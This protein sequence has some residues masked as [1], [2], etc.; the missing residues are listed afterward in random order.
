MCLDSCGVVRL[1]GDTATKQ[2]QRHPEIT[3]ATYALV[4][5]IIDEGEWLSDRS[6]HVVGFLGMDGELYS[7][8]V[9]STAAHDKTYLQSLHKTNQRRLLRARRRMQP[10]S[11]V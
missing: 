5:Q 11:D 3:P 4:Q 9:K 8:V 10:I 2:T 6:L 7:A 1:S